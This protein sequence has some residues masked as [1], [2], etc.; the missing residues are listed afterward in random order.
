MTFDCPKYPSKAESIRLQGMVK[1][2]VK[3]DGHQVTDVKVVSGHPVFREEAVK[4]V[5]TW[6]FADHDPTT[7]AV[8]YYYVNEGQYKKDPVTKCSA[9]MDL[10]ARVTVSTRF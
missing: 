5:R 7:F 8:T 4:N 10:P 1:M 6:K 2:E 9:K 3:T